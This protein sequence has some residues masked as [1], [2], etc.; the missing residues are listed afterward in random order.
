MG[1]RMGPHK[2]K[3]TCWINGANRQKHKSKR[4]RKTRNLNKQL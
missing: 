4:A 1:N 2:C 3:N